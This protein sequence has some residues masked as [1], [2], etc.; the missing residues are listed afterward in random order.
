MVYTRPRPKFAPVILFPMDTPADRL[1]SQVVYSLQEDVRETMNTERSKKQTIG[2]SEIGTDCDRC[3]ARK[4]SGIYVKP[5]DPSWKAQVGTF[6]HAGLEEHFG[7]KYGDLDLETKRYVPRNPNPTDT[8][9]AYHMERRLVIKDFGLFVLEGSCDM[10]IQGAS[11]GVVDDWKTQGTKKLAS[12]AAGKISPDYITQMHTYGLGYHLLGY[13]VTHVV[14]YALPRDGELDDAKPVLMRWDPQVAIDR[15][16]KIES[17]IEAA[18]VI[19]WP[20]LIQAQDRAG[21]CF[22]CPEYE[23]LETGDFIKDLTGS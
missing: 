8:D 6:I 1:A 15:L 23:A 4:V 3:L 20:M 10:Y 14:L 5:Q 17:M 11:F 16:A 21:H 19:G 18:N 9:W 22:S 7:Q 2:I 12:T 13:P